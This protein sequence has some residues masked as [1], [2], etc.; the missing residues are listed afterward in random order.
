VKIMASLLQQLENNEAILLMY[1]AD[2]LGADDRREVEQML[3]HDAALRAELEKI[4]SAQDAV[5][6]AIGAMDQANPLRVSTPVAVRQVSRLMKQ[7]QVDRLS[8]RPAEAA[9]SGPQFPWWAYPTAATGVAAMVLIGLMV[10]WG[11]KT[12][13][14]PVAGTGSP[15]TAPVFVVA[16]DSSDE[17]GSGLA[18][19]EQQA[20]VLS[21]RSSDVA[22]TASIFLTE[23]TQ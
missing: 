12:D 5:T 18:D 16:E 3:A 10:W 1:L 11:M 2:E 8:R 20:S 15:A 7:W 23:P 4:H 19:A 22:A 21:R 17:G 9:R 13:N 6:A 14:G